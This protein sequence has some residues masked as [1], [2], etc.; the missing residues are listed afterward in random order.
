MTTKTIPVP[1]VNLTID[2]LVDVIRQLD[3]DS[4]NRI[5]QAVLET[6]SNSSLGVLRERLAEYDPGVEFSDEE[7]AAEVRAVREERAARAKAGN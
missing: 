1:S 7:L 2:Q 4:L 6:T 3:P 5:G